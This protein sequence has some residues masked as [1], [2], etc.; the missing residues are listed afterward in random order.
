MDNKIEMDSKLPYE[1]PAVRT[2]QLAAEE[3]LVTKCKQAP[4]VTIRSIQ[5]CGAFS[6]NQTGSS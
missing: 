3:V 6:C 4:S 5:G 1:K 2:I